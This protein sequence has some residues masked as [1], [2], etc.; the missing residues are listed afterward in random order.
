MTLESFL[1][2]CTGLGLDGV[3]LTQYYF[4]EESARYLNHIKREAFR[5]GLEVAGTAV[6]GNFSN[7]D[8]EA[9]AEQVEHVKDWVIKSSMLGS[10]V[11]RVF[12]GG[13]PEG[14][15]EAEARRWVREGLTQCAVTAAEHGVVLALEN[16]GG[17][18]AS[19]DGV[20]DLIEPLS[21]NPWVGLNLDCGN[22]SGDIYEQFA[23]CAGHV[24]TTHAKV[25]AGRGDERVPVDYR[26]VV[27]TLRAAG[28]AGYLSIEYEE[29][30]DARIGVDRFAAYLRGCIVDA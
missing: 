15:E 7:A 5:R 25:S 24:V 9:R 30:G 12:A 28:Y 26:K 11:L 27:R 10:P 2:L 19:A 3:E 22:F 21:E 1:D 4:P 23:R 14:V 29:S 20:L 16:H 18:T 8:A 13:R 6:G 17:L